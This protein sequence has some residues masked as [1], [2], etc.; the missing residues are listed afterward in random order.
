MTSSKTIIFLFFRM[1]LEADCEDHFGT[2]DLFKIFAIEKTATESQ[3]KKA[4]YKQS[5][6]FHPD[7]CGLAE[8]E[9]NTKKFQSLSKIHKLL[10]LV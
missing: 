4:Y 2:K 7:K 1:G 9:E 10:R 6:K 5:L 3:I 8:K